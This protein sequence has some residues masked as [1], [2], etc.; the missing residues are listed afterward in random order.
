[1]Y[2]LPWPQRVTD[3]GIEIMSSLQVIFI[4]LLFV[5][6]SHLFLWMTAADQCVAALAENSSAIG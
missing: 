4:I 6:T 3:G 5:W 1:M 2:N